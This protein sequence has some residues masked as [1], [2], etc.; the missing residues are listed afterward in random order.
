MSRVSTFLSVFVWAALLVV[1]A[2]QVH[3]GSCSYA[4]DQNNPQLAT[5]NTPGLGASKLFAGNKVTIYAPELV[6]PLIPTGSF[7]YK[8]CHTVENK[9]AKDLFVPWNSAKEWTAFL[10]AASNASG[11]SPLSVVVTSGCCVPLKITQVGCAASNTTVQ[12]TTPLSLGSRSVGAYLDANGF[13]RDTAV[14]TAGD[15]AKFTDHGLSEWG[16]QADVSGTAF[17][18]VDANNNPITYQVAYTCDSTIDPL[19]YNDPGHLGNGYGGWIKMHDSGSCAPIDGSCATGVNTF[20]NDTPPSDLSSLCGTGSIFDALYGLQTT[21]TGWTWKC[22]GTGGS[23][24]GVNGNQQCKDASCVASVSHDGG[25]GSADQSSVVP[26]AVLTNVSPNLCDAGSTLHPGSFTAGQSSDPYYT[27]SCDGVGSGNATSCQAYNQ[28]KINGACGSLTLST[29]RSNAS[30]MAGYVSTCLNAISS[31]DATQIAAKCSPLCSSGTYANDLNNGGDV[32]GIGTYSNWHWHCSG[33]NGGNASGDCA[34]PEADIDARCGALGGAS[35]TKAS[36]FPSSPSQSD[37]CFRPEETPVPTNPSLVMDDATNGHWKWT[38]SG[39][40]IGS[41]TDCYSYLQPGFFHGKCASFSGLNATQIAQFTQTD[42]CTIGT[43]AGPPY[44][45]NGSWWWNCVGSGTNGDN[46]TDWC[47]TGDTTPQAQT[48]SCA[49]TAG[50]CAYGTSSTPSWDAVNKLYTWTC[51][52]DAN[53]T[54]APC[55]GSGDPTKFADG[56]CGISNNQPT[57]TQP[58]VA[59]N[60]CNS[61][62]P[63][64]VNGSGPWTWY[65]YPTGGSTVVSPQCRASACTPC[66]DPQNPINNYSRQNSTDRTLTIG[67]C[68]ITGTARWTEYDSIISISGSTGQVTLTDPA[69]SYSVP[70]YSTS[71]TL[72]TSSSGLP[73]CPQ[74]YVQLQGAT[75]A[76][77]VVGSSSPSSACSAYAPN[78]VIPATVTVP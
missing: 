52:G 53:T 60:L 1:S 12:L 15:A 41:S 36:D 35:F 16:A 39:L 55:S 18:A 31:G 63:G 26:P 51:T 34:T 58:N 75:N 22:K 48:G 42:L 2:S 29:N 73:F 27:W 28:S 8:Q 13:P 30:Q 33:A 45:M 68:N 56:A 50:A 19:I 46:S 37:L 3:A 38:C 4:Q 25:C 77:V 24:C 44:E 40:G 71:A 7:S 49:A 5:C 43:L 14:S 78:T 70:V 74:C 57:Y 72:L 76:Q 32:N 23:G 62:A 65:C 11:A 17:A 59:S 21:S 9:G 10:Q 54:P 64:P 69:G 6:D 20:P 61:G 67:S 66:N 47:A